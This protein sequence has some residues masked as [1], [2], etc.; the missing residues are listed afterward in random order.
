[1]SQLRIKEIMK[2]ILLKD[3]INNFFLKRIFVITICATRLSN[4]TFNSFKILRENEIFVVKRFLFKSIMTL[5][6]S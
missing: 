1:M 4:S 3:Q 6:I 5:L 2:K